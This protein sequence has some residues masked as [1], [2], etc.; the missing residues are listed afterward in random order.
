MI[1]LHSS[2]YEFADELYVFRNP[3]NDKELCAVFGSDAKQTI[4]Q[5]G[6]HQLE[7]PV[8]STSEEARILLKK[9]SGKDDGGNAANPELDSE[10]QKALMD[11]YKS[12]EERVEALTNL[13]KRGASIKQA[14]GMMLAAS[15]AKS[16]ARTL[17][18]LLALGGSVRDR[19][20]YGSTPLHVAAA[21]SNADVAAILLKEGADI[22]ATDNDGL[23][24]NMVLAKT[25]ERNQNME[26]EF[27]T[28]MPADDRARQDRIQT[29]FDA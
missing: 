3:D 19:D 28:A 6:W 13:V 22:E 4:E 12:E 16:G 11:F 1:Q 27:G 18:I 7:I 24:P 2:R 29:L 8:I 10:L 17:K 14:K 26:M 21:F 15:D 25:V 9:E 23:T 20:A 5:G